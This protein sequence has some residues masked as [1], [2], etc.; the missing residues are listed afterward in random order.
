MLATCCVLVRIQPSE[1]NEGADESTLSR[2]RAVGSTPT[3]N[4]HR[5]DRHE[6]TDAG[7]TCSF[8]S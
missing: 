2:L 8:T 1:I 6:L 7:S 5:D 4:N 3:T